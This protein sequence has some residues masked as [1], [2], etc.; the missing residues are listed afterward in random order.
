M[1]GIAGYFGTR[2]LGGAAAEAMFAAIARRGPDANHAVCW[3][4]GQRSTEPAGAQRALMH[5]RLS[6]RDPRPEA[7]Q[8]MGNADGSL[9]ICYNGEV[10]GWE[11]ERRA[12]EAQ[13]AAF[14]T[15]SDT[16]FILRGY[17][18]WG[19]EALLPKLRG[20]FAFAL[21]DL[22]AGKLHLVR[23]RM[24]L[25]PMVY[26]HDEAR[27]TLAFGS[28]VRSVLPAVPAAERD[29]DPEGIDA[30]LAHR[31]IPAP[32]TVFRAIRRLEN[33][34]RLEF[35]LASGRLTKRR[36]WQPAPNGR[37]PADVLDEAVR[38][39]TVA[40]RPVGVFLSGGI[41]S[42]VVA[43]RLAL[44]GYTNIESFT[45]GFDD[46][47]MDESALAAQ[48]A[49]SL[50]LP[51]TRI[52]MASD[53]SGDFEQVVADLDEPFADPSAFPT[54]ALAREV[55]K[56]VKVV[57]CGDGG[58]EMF[59][60]YKRYRQHLRSAWRRHL[61]AA[62]ALRPAGNVTPGKAERLRLEAA[63][64]WP[65]AWSL[66]FSGF[67]ATEREGLQPVL[68][69]VPAHRWRAAEV[70]DT[71]PLGTLLELDRLN[72][73][74]EYILRKADLTTMAHGLEGR[75]PLIDHVFV[76]SLAGLPS[77]Q[78]FTQ[79]AKAW[80][81]SRCPPCQSLGLLTMK[82]R[83]FNPPIGALVREGLAARLPGFGA[84]LSHASD[85]QLDAAA[86]ERYVE[87]WRRDGSL[88]E[89]LL[90]LLMLD[91]SLRQLGRLRVAAHG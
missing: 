69:R 56:S 36:Y 84:R 21:L 61:P 50:G 53:V 79:P 54:W 47:A 2:P 88:S 42:S 75:A 83:G 58:D 90:Q 37:D 65:D 55:S 52:A 51:N 35:D 64:S 60:G 81:A 62:A 41:D 70:A 10:Y 77:A 15:T 80:L 13:G 29:F 40:D 17:E 78:R 28:L 43:S 57:L 4:D 3:R 20:M 73:L 25:K 38:L 46:A 24:G 89:G 74:P 44:Q 34:H 91:E 9:W 12:L 39:R 6:I 67:S 27:C 45:A 5:A 66:R 18:A 87:A 85:G 32:R 26:H 33:A 11:D 82:K 30:Y 22:R 68:G 49:A 8:P 31:T 72:Y 59:A 63:L 16:E 19:I 14:R 48:I 7:D 23:D 1:C 86:I 71:D 76:E